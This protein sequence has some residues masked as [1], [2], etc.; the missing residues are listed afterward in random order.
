MFY[1]SLDLGYFISGSLFYR[2]MNQKE[3]RRVFILLSPFSLGTWFNYKHGQLDH[4][5][6]YLLDFA[7]MYVEILINSQ[8]L[9][10]LSHQTIQ[11]KTDK[12]YIAVVQNLLFFITHLLSF[13][14]IYI[15]GL[16][17]KLNYI[18]I[19]ILDYI[20]HILCYC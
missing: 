20:K 13:N 4:F 3:M 16:Q 9:I 11:I 1:S 8:W 5:W 6:Y 18:S 2:I 14:S 15:W 12:Y 7:V 19:K 10:K 17:Y